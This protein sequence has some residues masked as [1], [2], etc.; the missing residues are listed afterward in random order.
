[1]HEG[2]YR[3]RLRRTR[4]LRSTSSRVLSSAS[5]SAQV[6]KFLSG[7]PSHQSCR[8]SVKE[9]TPFFCEHGEYP[10]ILICALNTYLLL[11]SLLLTSRPCTFFC[12][13]SCSRVLSHVLTRH[14]P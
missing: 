10:Y 9:A 8:L 14:M 2:T 6:T 11:F 4:G 3:T 5:A 13:H 12:S 7:L 1:M